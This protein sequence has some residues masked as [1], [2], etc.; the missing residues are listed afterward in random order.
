[1]GQP[2]R[3]EGCG[4]YGPPV[5]S[6]RDLLRRAGMGF[7]TLALIDLLR[8]DGLLAAE[9][10]KAA[11]KVAP[12]GKAKS[13]I[14]L[15]MGGGPSQVDTWDPKPELTK[16]DGKDVPDSIARDVPRVVRARLNGLFASPYKFRRMGQSGLPVSEMFPETGKLVD[17]ICVL[18]SCRHDSPIHAPAEYIATTGTQV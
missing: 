1:M 7:G 14:F 17:D 9:G 4:N 2:T 15:F 8:R 11:A 5:W 3:D 13:V 18:R 16:L 10:D 6:R 12:K